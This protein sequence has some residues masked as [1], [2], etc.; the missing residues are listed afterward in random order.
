MTKGRFRFFQGQIVFQGSKNFREQ[1][2]NL[3]GL[4][5][6]SA[7]ASLCSMMCAYNI[8]SLNVMEIIRN[9]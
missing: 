2:P 7:C 4:V 9:C 6:L 3:A 1:N 8:L 5:I